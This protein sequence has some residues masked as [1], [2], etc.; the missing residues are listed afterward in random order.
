MEHVA[1]FLPVHCLLVGRSACNPDEDLT[2]EDLER[3]VYEPFY[4]FE[5][6]LE[7][8]LGNLVVCEGCREEAPR[9]L[10]D[11]IFLL[12]GDELPTE[13]QFVERR[14]EIVR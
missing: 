2:L 12:S 3:G 14:M 5:L 11:N 8:R 6:R 9:R 7:Q 13:D 1:K 4:I 10:P